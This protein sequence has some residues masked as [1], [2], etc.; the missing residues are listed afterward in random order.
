MQQQLQQQLQQRVT[1]MTFER[2]RLMREIDQL[3]NKLAEYEKPEEFTKLGPF[4]IIPNVSDIT[5]NLV[6]TSYEVSGPPDLTRHLASV[7]P[8]FDV[9]FG[10]ISPLCPITLDTAT[11]IKSKIDTRATHF[12]FLYPLAGVSDMTVQQKRMLNLSDPRVMLLIFGGYIYTNQ[13]MGMIQINTIA[14]NSEDLFFS[15]PYQVPLACANILTTSGRAQPITIAELI[16]MGYESFAWINPKE[17]FAGCIF[18]TTVDNG[19][20]VYIHKTN[21]QKNIYFEVI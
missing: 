12:A 11:K 17:S 9:L 6:D 15:G 20:F 13:E 10:S 4:G 3:H 5:I 8:N 19:A 14:Q 7:N 21:N 16:Q 2:E 18:P 1:D